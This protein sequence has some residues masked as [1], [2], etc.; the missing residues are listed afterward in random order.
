VRRNSIAASVDVSPF[1]MGAP[2]LRHQRRHWHFLGLS[3]TC[4]YGQ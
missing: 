2:V 3:G 4:A 1:T